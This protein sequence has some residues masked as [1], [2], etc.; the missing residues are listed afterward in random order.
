[1]AIVLQCIYSLVM[2]INLDLTESTYAI[3]RYMLI[4]AMFW[5]ATDI[6]LIALPCRGRSQRMSRISPGLRGHNGRHGFR[7]INNFS[8][9]GIEAIT[10]I[11]VLFTST[12]LH[13]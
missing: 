7:K 4:S 1:M 9:W 12:I 10:F 5:L 3:S 8:C 13:V 6:I 11:S 2:E